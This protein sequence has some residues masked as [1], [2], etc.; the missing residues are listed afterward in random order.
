M[1]P[2]STE[3]LPARRATTGPNDFETS[4]STSTG[5]AVLLVGMELLVLKGFNA[6]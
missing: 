4:R 1:E 3:M 6:N 2:A 5:A